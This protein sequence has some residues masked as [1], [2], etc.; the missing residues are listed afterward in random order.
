M[1]EK[2]FNLGGLDLCR[3]LSDY[4]LGVLH[5]GL[6]SS[7]N[8]ENLFREETNTFLPEGPPSPNNSSV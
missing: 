7:Q 3:T 2:Q 8:T 1:V 4:D 5:L 6:S